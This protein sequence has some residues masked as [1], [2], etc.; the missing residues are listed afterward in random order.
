M[1]EAVYCPRLFYLEWVDRDFDDNHFTVEGRFVHRR[2]DDGEPTTPLADPDV[3]WKARS[4]ELS[5]AELGVTGKIDLVEADGG[6][7]MPVET[8][9]G[10]A[11][12]VPEGAYEPELV[13]LCLYGLLLREAGYQVTKGAF[14]FAASRQRVEV[15]FT[16]QL[17]ARTKAAVALAK[18]VA[19]QKVPP[20]PLVA[21]PKCIG[22]SLSGLCLPD[23]TN[24]LA[25]VPSTEPPRPLLPA[26]DDAQPLY[27]QEVGAR[28][29]VSGHCV[30][31]KD[32][33]G[34][35]VMDAPLVDV[36][37][38]VV[39]GNVQ[40]S[41]QA[42]K[43]LSTRGLPVVWL[44][45]GGWLSGLLDGLGHGQ[46][47]LRRAQYQ[48]ADDPQRALSLARSFVAAKIANART[49]LRRNL[50]ANSPG[51]MLELAQLVERAEA[52]ENLEV[53][54]GHEGNAAR[55]YF[56]HFGSLLVDDSLGTFDFSVRNRR[57]P[58]D[59]VNA[60]LSFCYSMLTKDLAVAARL[61]GFDPYLGFLHQPRAGR[62]SLALDVMEEFR[63]IVADSVVVSVINTKMVG[64]SDFIRRGVGVTLNAEGRKKVLRA[65][66]RRLSEKVTHPV[67][68]YRV[69]YRRIFEMQCRLL[70]RHLRG[71]LP[72]YPA[73][74]TR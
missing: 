30:T 25:G 35:K 15:P 49:M 41:T 7:V 52:A 70:A 66:E 63:P 34:R 47:A 73:F 65:W 8:K 46:V 16:D 28:V 59:A 71:E 31:V 39:M 51:L 40:V 36:S 48:A 45:T 74:T 23:E 58:K 42:L 3:P 4:V 5:S 67:F 22:C 2:V 64:P 60:L 72:T 43:E 62:F 9:R 68:G 21:S 19:E 53:L 24:L 69:S 55:L 1:N 50:E 44:S 33:E 20:P 14:W 61:V 32:S 12:D 57:P 6:E 17:I 56:E 54:L 38:L 29:G 10:K 18:S 37:H 26:R 11:P 27:V 13:Q